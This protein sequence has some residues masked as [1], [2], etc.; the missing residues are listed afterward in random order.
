MNQAGYSQ[1]ILNQSRL[2]RLTDCLQEDVDTMWYG[3]LS[4]RFATEPFA[5][6]HLNFI[7]NKDKPV[8]IIHLFT[9]V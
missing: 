5:P 4:L 3:S 7:K 2:N 6:P 1:L 8:L 9:K